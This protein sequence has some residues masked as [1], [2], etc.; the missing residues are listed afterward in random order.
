MF[1]SWGA[2]LPKFTNSVAS[3]TVRRK[4]I[5]KSDLEGMERRYEATR[6]TQKINSNC[7]ASQQE[8]SNRIKILSKMV[9]EEKRQ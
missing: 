7:S 1:V 2:A 9:L 8:L 6:K 3:P 4:K 5:P